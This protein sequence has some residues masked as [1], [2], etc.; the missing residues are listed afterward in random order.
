MKTRIKLLLLS[1]ILSVSSVACSN[2]DTI[3]EIVVESESNDVVDNEENKQLIFVDTEKYLSLC[4]KVIP[5][6]NYEEYYLSETEM[7]NIIETT[8]NT[9]KCD[10]ETFDMV[11]LIFSIKNNNKEY[12]DTKDG[13]YDIFNIGDMYNDIDP[14]LLEE[15]VIGAICAS[16]LDDSG[17]KYE[18]YCKMKEIKIVVNNN[19][20]TQARFSCL[21]KNE[22]N[23]PLDNNILEL[24]LD[25]ILE[26][27][28]SY[29]DNYTDFPELYDDPGDIYNYIEKYVLSH[30]LF[31]V[32]QFICPCREEKGESNLCIQIMNENG[33][34]FDS[35]GKTLIESSA[36]S[37]LYKD[38]IYDLKDGP[39]VYDFYRSDEAMLML[40]SLFSSDNVEDY[41]DAI[42]DS[43]FSAFYDFFDLDSAE[44]KFDF[45]KILYSLEA[46][47]FSNLFLNKYDSNL[48]SITRGEAKD[49][50]GT[51][52]YIDLYKMFIKNSIEYTSTFDISLEENILLNEIARCILLDKASKLEDVNG[53]TEYLWDE[54]FKD[55]F[56]M[57]DEIYYNY[58]GEF[59][60]MTRDELDFIREEQF[61]ALFDLFEIH[62]YD[63]VSIV[64][65]FPTI[66]N[67]TFAAD[68]FT[69]KK[70]Y[71][72][73]KFS[74]E[75]EDV[76]IL[77]KQMVE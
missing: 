74:S 67:I 18:N 51:A 2:D 24:N 17:D 32:K 69:S 36:E 47:D 19:I 9:Y 8:K 6:Y 40:L 21:L 43:N 16:L 75:R 52:C 10:N 73:D 29:M 7:E 33:E 37:Q 63:E 15:S 64:N 50:I 54:E 60:N 41:Y 39:Y 72:D 58:L 30:E 57:L 65:R 5:K 23:K 4:D 34:K 61:L 25:N 70:D 42:I 38:D 68:I 13:V 1:L 56:L 26:S 45:Y 28:N 71:F 66:L 55:D 59:Y 53:E 48:E 22:N 35:F 76:K 44:K 31:H 49:L 20:S 3:T 27:Y 11:E 62:S 12:L 46:I 77:I 14:L